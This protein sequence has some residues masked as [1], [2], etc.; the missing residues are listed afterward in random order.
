[1][2]DASDMYALELPAGRLAYRD[3]GTGQPLVLLHGGFLDHRMWDGQV[4]ALASHYRVIAPDARG[5]GGSA[6]ASRPFRNADDL[7]GLLRHLGTGPAVLVGVSMGGALAVDTALE[8][9]ELVRALV[10][11]GVGTSEPD[12]R[13]PWITE[14]QAEQARA[15]AAGDAKAYV[16]AFML[17]APGPHRVLD[18]L[19]PRVVRL[20]R[21]MTERTVAKH[22][23]DGRDWRVPVTDTWERAA[24]IT[25]PLLAINGAL[26][27]DDHLRMA[28]RL[29]RTV[30][31]GR[32]T[33]I[34]GTAHYPNM[35]R[36]EAFNAILGD[37]LRAVSA[38]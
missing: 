37:F 16:D 1:M 7:G 31:N 36:P 12:W 20:L 26:D 11:S 8:H 29:V 23:G 19:D 33:R 13:D 30:A 24:K 34:E 27:A 32:A 18:D 14:I 21:D 3:V 15:L 10:V 2:T 25:V 4:A 35:E 22:T 17:L 38:G 6:N 5:H 28:E 9:P